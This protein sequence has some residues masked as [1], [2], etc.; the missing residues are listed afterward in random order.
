MTSHDHQHDHMDHQKTTQMSEPCCDDEPMSSGHH[1]MNHMMSVCSVKY[2]DK[3][4][5]FRHV[6]YVLWLIHNKKYIVI[7]LSFN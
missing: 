1:M 5:L 2:F 6:Y 4:K 3:K 7:M